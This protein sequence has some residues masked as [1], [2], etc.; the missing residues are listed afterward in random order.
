MRRHSLLIG[1]G[2]Y[3]AEGGL[4]PLKCSARDVAAMAEVLGAPRFMGPDPRCEK[5]VDPSHEVAL[6]EIGR[7]LKTV[8]KDDVLIVYFSGHGLRDSNG[9]LFL[10]FT[11]TDQQDLDFTALNVR[12][13]TENL[14][15]K[16]L[17]RVLVVLD[18][19]H[20]GAAGAMVTKDSL[21]ARIN[22]AER[23]L[24]D[25]TGIYYLTSSA[26]TQV[27]VEG[28]ENS[29][30]TRHFVN[31]IRD[32]SADIDGKGEIT[33]QDLAQYLPKKVAE[34]APRQT[35]QLSAKAASGTFVVAWNA[36]ARLAKRRETDAARRKAAFE[37]ARMR[38]L[39]ASRVNDVDDEFLQE[40]LAWMGENA[41][42]PV[43]APVF[44]LLEEFGA[45]RLGLSRLV[46]QWTPA[47]APPPV[48]AVLPRAQ[49]VR[50]TKA[51]SD[52]FLSSL[53]QVENEL[54][55]P[56]RSEPIPRAAIGLAVILN[57]VNAAIVAAIFGLLNPEESVAS[58]SAAAGVALTCAIA[59]GAG[60]AARTDLPWWRSLVVSGLL[61]VTP[62]LFGLFLLTFSLT[63]SPAGSYLTYLFLLSLPLIATPFVGWLTYLILHDGR[64][65]NGLQG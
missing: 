22:E 19:C 65:T 33:V 32:G 49:P 1:V 9:D 13:L 14:E 55:G 24:S 45:R 28:T 30:F 60:L 11:N 2:D 31:G 44:L 10:C 41:E 4:T 40:V 21:Q 27:A 54:R 26:S 38:M 58:V 63:S 5:V 16:F 62:L 35:P 17:R 36:A 59:A 23:A 12:R 34:E 18:C 64:R 46:L 3:Q 53:V 43:D 51:P 61:S 7:F 48:V 29:I 37:A 15:G 50:D 56:S 42:C 6:R 20:S 57:A 8:P 52:A 39:D 25:G 47:R